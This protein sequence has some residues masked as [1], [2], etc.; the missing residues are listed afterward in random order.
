MRLHEGG[1]RDLYFS[2]LICV[3]GHTED[4]II[5]LEQQNHRR[6]HSSVFDLLSKLCSEAVL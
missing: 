2:R 1:A 5:M 6:I 3:A 4:M